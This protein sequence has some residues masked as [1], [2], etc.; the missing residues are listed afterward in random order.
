MS[1]AAAQSSAFFAEVVRHREVF[2]I[3]DEGGFPAPMISAG[4]RAQPFWSRET[5]AQR[6]I[7][8]VAAYGGFAP[9]RITLDE[10]QSRWIPGLA[11]D[12]FRIGVNWSGDF[13]TGYDMTPD[14]VLAGLTARDRR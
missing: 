10:F 4:V 1:V 5:R 14:E 12:G 11:R 2:T 13:A 6:I 8:R 7:T 3:R 9:V